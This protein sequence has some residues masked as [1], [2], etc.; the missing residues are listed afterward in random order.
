MAYVE[1]LLPQKW[2]YAKS[3][4]TTT[5]TTMMTMTSTMTTTEMTTETT[6]MTKLISITITTATTQINNNSF[7]CKK[8]LLFQKEAKGKLCFGCYL[9]DFHGAVNAV[10]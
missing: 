4:N 7:N 5:T 10:V 1:Y 6:T 3:Y 9:I 2:C 8:L